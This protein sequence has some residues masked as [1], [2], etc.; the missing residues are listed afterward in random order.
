MRTDREFLFLLIQTLEK[1]SMLMFF[2]RTN[3]PVLAIL[4]GSPIS[5][6]SIGFL[7]VTDFGIGGGPPPGG[8]GGGGTV[9]LETHTIEIE[10][11]GLSVKEE[12]TENLRNFKDLPVMKVSHF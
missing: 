7:S 8:G 9:I 3:L 10:S 2:I 4:P 5:A 1:N 12:I 11:D 6:V